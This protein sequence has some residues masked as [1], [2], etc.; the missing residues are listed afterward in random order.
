MNMIEGKCLIRTQWKGPTNHSPS[1]IIAKWKGASRTV[2]WEY[3]I[4]VLENH[5]R[6]VMSLLERDILPSNPVGIEGLSLI[7]ADGLDKDGFT[8]IIAKV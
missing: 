3:G 7:V 1:R 6:A 2:A 5:R 8:F 4:S